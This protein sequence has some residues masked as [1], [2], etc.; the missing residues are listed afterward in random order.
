MDKLLER[1]DSPQKLPK[2]M[3]KFVV[4][5]IKGNP[6]ELYAMRLSGDGWRRVFKNEGESIIE[7]FNTP[8]PGRL[9][10]LFRRL[11]GVEELWKDWSQVEIDELNDFVCMRGAIAHNG[12]DATYVKI[13][14]LQCHRL[15]IP[16]IAIQLDNQMADYI[17]A[18]FP[19]PDRAPWRRRL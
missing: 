14:Q 2:N 10:E 16:E 15:K 4:Q 1:A 17:V 18:L 13:Q 6:N 3:Q 19:K 7:N 9:E 5:R 8:K 12:S 11:V